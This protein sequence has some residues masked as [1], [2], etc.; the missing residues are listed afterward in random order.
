[1]SK[2]LHFPQFTRGERLADAVVHI[3]GVSASLAAA[4]ALLVLAVWHSQSSLAL[5]EPGT[6][7][8][9]LFSTANLSLAVYGLGLVAVFACSA[10]YNMVWHPNWKEVLRRL[11][12]AA[13]FVMIA[14]SYTPFSL[15]VIGGTW[16]WALFAVVWA[17]AALGVALK[18]FLPRRFER[19]AIVLYLAQGWSVLVVVE[20]L[21]AAL[22]TPAL[23]LLVAGGVI[24]TLGVVF[25]LWRSLP[26]H[27][28]IWHALVLIAAAC[29]Y[30]A[31]LDAVALG[32]G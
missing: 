20:P 22:S 18:L 6:F 28:A 12:H 31:I 32:T 9:T 23:S 10:A 26:Y 19:A 25:H 4:P 5:I 2:P 1:M 24:Y 29:H 3:L 7:G 21:A 13:I 27:N 15:A 30:L 8:P 14:G 17:V 16:G 11:D